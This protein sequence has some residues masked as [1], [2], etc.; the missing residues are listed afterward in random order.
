MA[1]PKLRVSADSTGFYINDIGGDVTGSASGAQFLLQ[2]D[3]FTS[4]REY[5]KI[6][7]GS[8]KTGKNT[9][10]PYDRVRLHLSWTGHIDINSGSVT[11]GNASDADL[12]FLMKGILVDPSLNIIVGL[13]QN[14]NPE[15]QNLD[16]GLGVGV[17]GDTS[18]PYKFEGSVGSEELKF[19]DAWLVKSTSITHNSNRTAR[20]SIT[21]MATSDWSD[22]AAV[23]D[24]SGAGD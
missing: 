15:D 18:W 17:L 14:P 24:E 20:L 22:L 13:T 9:V 10:I 11:F 7:A 19:T 5:V 8:G 23:I 6:T 2:C 16:G 3:Q 1:Y 21:L 12:T 4:R